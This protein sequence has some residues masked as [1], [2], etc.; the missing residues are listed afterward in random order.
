DAND[1]GPVPPDY[2]LG[3]GD[4]LVLVLTGDTERSYELTVTREGMVFIPAVGGIPVANLTMRQLEDVL[5]ARLGRVYSGIRR[6]ADATAHFQV[7]V[8]KL[9]SNQ[10]S[11]LGDVATPGSYRI[12]KLGTVLT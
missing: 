3:P 5:W 7:T 2:R 6:G 11:V 1:A 12:S 4:N 10:V 9:G 8:A